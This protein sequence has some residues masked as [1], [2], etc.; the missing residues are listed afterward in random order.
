MSE[1]KLLE[2]LL[3][4]DIF[5]EEGGVYLIPKMMRNIFFFDLDILKSN[6]G[7]RLKSKHF[8]KL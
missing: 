3:C 7:G 5:Q 6:L 8:E 2:E 4:L 1:A